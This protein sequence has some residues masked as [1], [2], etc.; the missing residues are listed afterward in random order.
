MA[1]LRPA[2]LL[3]IHTNMPATVP[4]EIRAR[5]R[6]R[7]AAW[8]Q[9]ETFS[10]EIRA[11]FRSLRRPSPVIH[12]A[13]SWSRARLVESRDQVSGQL[14]GA[15]GF[16]AGPL[17]DGASVRPP[18]RRVPGVTPGLGPTVGRVFPRL[19]APVDGHVQ[20]P[21]GGGH[22]LAAATAGV[23]RLEHPLVVAD[24]A[25][26]MVALPVTTLQELRGRLLDRVPRHVQAQEVPVADARLVR[27]LAER[28]VRG[29][30]GVDVGQ[31]A[32]LAVEERAALA[33]LRG[34]PAG[35][36]GVEV[37]DELLAAFEDVEDR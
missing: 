10:A 27:A 19:L 2:G 20:Q 17:G 1:L 6:R 15:A 4:P 35:P 31:L 28:G 11:T 37:R 16:D 29:V 23:V 33:L 32:D 3:G 21:V 7:P 9:P 14:V 8:E 34:G 24:V 26:K 18:D 12:G 30:A 5:I 13:G 22:D 36:P 25:D